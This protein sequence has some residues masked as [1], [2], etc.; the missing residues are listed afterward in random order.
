[1]DYAGKCFVYSYRLENRI[2][3]ERLLIVA[4]IQGNRLLEAI[5]GSVE[6]NSDLS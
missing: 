4:V 1:M 2:E 6:D 3:V 5:T